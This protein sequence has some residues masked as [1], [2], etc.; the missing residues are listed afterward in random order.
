MNT[1]TPPDPARVPLNQLAVDRRSPLLAR[2]VPVEREDGPEPV[3]VAA[4]QSSV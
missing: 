4:F 1:T 3:A 2:I